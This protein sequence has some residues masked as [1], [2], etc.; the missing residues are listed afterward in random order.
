MMY[1]AIVIGGGIGGLSAASL[2]SNAGFKTLLLEKSPVLGGRAKVIDRNG[3]TL[4]Y[5]IHLIRFGEY[6]LLPRLFKKI[7]K[8][9]DVVRLG[10]S[11]LFINQNEY[12]LPVNMEGILKTDYLN[13]EEKQLTM[14][15]LLSILREN[16][17]NQLDTPISRYLEP[18]DIPQKIMRLMRIISG[19]LLVVPEIDKASLG[20][21]IGLIK[22]AV[23]YGVGAGYPVGGW[24]TII[25]EMES[26]I[27]DNGSEIR[28]KSKA[29]SI[30]LGDSGV[31]GVIVG[32]SLITGENVI[33]ATDFNEAIRL[34]IQIKHGNFREIYK[35]PVPTTGVGIDIGLKGEKLDYKGLLVWENPFIMGIITSNL[36]PNLVPDGFQYATFLMPITFERY[37]E[38]KD[39]S[40]NSL[41]EI[42]NRWLE[43]HNVTIEWIRKLYFPIVDGAA[44]IISQHWKKRVSPIT[45]IRG[46][47]ITGDWVGSAGAGSDI[48]VGASLKIFSDIQEK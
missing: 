44:P 22:K 47:Y 41:I 3:F 8:K 40:M 18:M 36:D 29:K 12:M 31:K 46:L 2:L 15:L 10:E 39:A 20:E 14:D 38:A 13:K 25:K 21:L 17:D 11:K 42:I 30:V 43:R 1:E 6:G 16:S 5:G 23:E 32:N 4:D 34:L 33:I 24:K 27:I 28:L 45:P 35:K 37:S 9:L 19:L 48:A 7:G 26:T